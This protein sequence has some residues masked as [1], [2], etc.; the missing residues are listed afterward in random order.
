MR[1]QIHKPQTVKLASSFKTLTLMIAFHYYHLIKKTLQRFFRGRKRIDLMLTTKNL[2]RD[3]INSSIIP[4]DTIIQS[5]HLGIVIDI[6]KEVF[7]CPQSI[8]NFNKLNR[9]FHSTHTPSLKKYLELIVKQ[10]TVHKLLPKFHE[11]FKRINQNSS[12]AD[13]IEYDELDKM[14]IK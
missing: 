5:E 6:S 3:V 12:L 1:T 2:R 11:L 7:C 9:K 14:V 8:S 4:N 13:K 10:I